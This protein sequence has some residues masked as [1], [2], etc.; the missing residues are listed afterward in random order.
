MLFF[1]SLIPSF[2]RLMIQD[3]KQITVLLYGVLYMLINVLLLAMRAKLIAV[4]RKED[5]ENI[6][7]S[8]MYRIFFNRHGLFV[9]LLYIA[10]L[11]IAWFQPKLGLLF[12]ILLTILSFFLNGKDKKDFDEIAR[13]PKGTLH[14]LVS[15]TEQEK[16]EFQIMYA[17]YMRSQ[18]GMR[19]GRKRRKLKENLLKELEERFQFTRQEAALWYKHSRRFELAQKRMHARR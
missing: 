8:V 3:I 6:D 15:M 13:L 7:V 10:N 11:I 18:M 4:M 5:G 9:L 16:Q 17:R 19:D 1:L 14:R 12:Y 2:T